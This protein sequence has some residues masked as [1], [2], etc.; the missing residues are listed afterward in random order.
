[1]VPDNITGDYPMPKTNDAAL[2]AFIARKAEID[3]ALDR[4]RAASD[5]HFFASLEDV[6]LGNV[7]ALAHHAGLLRRMT[8]AICVEPHS[9]C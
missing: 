6:H 3:A 1:M 4:I 9:G 7:T 2:A 5:D 8:D